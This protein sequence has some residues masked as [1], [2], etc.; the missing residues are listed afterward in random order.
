MEAV[1]KQASVQHARHV[2]IP[3][4]IDADTKAVELEFKSGKSCED[5]M[6]V[7]SNDNFAKLFGKNIRG[8]NVA[9]VRVEY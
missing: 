5:A 9:R 1:L 8:G 6:I 3:E 2:R 7:L 4:G